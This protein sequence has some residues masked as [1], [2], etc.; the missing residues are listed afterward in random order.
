MLT[1][2]AKFKAVKTFGKRLLSTR[3][4]EFKEVSVKVPWGQV[5]GK[6][7]EPY[8]ARPVLSLHGWMVILSIISC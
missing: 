6:W 2:I 8:D 4:R 3:N 1:K 7:W 5:S